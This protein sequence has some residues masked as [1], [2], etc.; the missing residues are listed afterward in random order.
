[1]KIEPSFVKEVLHE[2]YPDSQAFLSFHNDFECL[3]AIVLSAQTTDKAVNK[4]T[5]ELFRYFPT[6]EAMAV[7]PVS[8]IYSLISSLGLASSKARYLSML[9]KILMNQYGSTVPHDFK[10]LCSL[11]G[12]GTKTAGVFLL[13]R[14]EAKTFPVDTH[15]K[16]LAYRF[17][18][19]ALEDSPL[20]VTKKLEKIFPKEE[21]NFLHH[22]FISFGRKICKALNPQ[23]AECP[24]LDKCPYLAK[25]KRSTS[26]K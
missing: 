5:P 3:V 2:K 7:A 1:M 22:A 20:K 8:E 10:T 24:F 6:I 21:W 26:L 23:C 18:Y 11:P 14:D 9:S 16:R 4:V 25:K 17:G 15:I 13:E 19:S 12:V